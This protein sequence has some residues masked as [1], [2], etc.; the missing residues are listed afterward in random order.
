MTADPPAPASP[1]AAPP[2]RPY[3]DYKPAPADWLPRTPGHWESRRFKFFARVTGGLID[4]RE[5]PYASTMLI[6]PDHVESGTGRVLKLVTAAEQGASSG[7]YPVKAGQIIYSKIRPVLRKATV[8]EADCL[9][10]ADMYAITVNPKLAAA[11]FV[12]KQMLAE[13]HTQYLQ[14]QST[15]ASIPKV[16]RESLGDLWFSLPPLPEQ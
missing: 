8:A 15:R 7:K 3:P 1:Q 14:D 5:E 11:D 9:C 4:P 6:S 10:S 13:G 2:L 12:A 16:N